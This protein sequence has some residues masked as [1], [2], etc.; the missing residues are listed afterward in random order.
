MTNV[1]FVFRES[2]SEQD[3]NRIVKRVL[4]MPGVRA[5][6]RISPNA[7]KPVLRRLWYAEVADQSVAEQVIGSLRASDKVQSAELPA[8]RRLV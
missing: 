1:M 7:T 6:G 4:S 8:P 5:A 2:A 3:Q